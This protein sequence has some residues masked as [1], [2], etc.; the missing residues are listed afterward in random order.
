MHAR[1]R[2]FCPYCSTDIQP[3]EEIVRVGP[4]PG[5]FRWSHATCRP[6]AGGQMAAGYRVRVI[7]STN[8]HVRIGEGRQFV[9]RGSAIGEARGLASLTVSGTCRTQVIEI[10][11]GSVVWDAASN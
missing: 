2:D 7:E 4:N 5:H 10:N 9:R 3:G 6:A 1:Y 8:P 11:T